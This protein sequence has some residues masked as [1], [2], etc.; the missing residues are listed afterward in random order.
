MASEA[1]SG[2][3]PPSHPIWQSERRSASESKNSMPS[4]VRSMTM[5]DLE[6]EGEL[7]LAPGWALFVGRPGD[8]APHAHQALQLC[9]SS[10]NPLFIGSGP[11][12][13]TTG[14]C[15]AIAANTLH[16]ITGGDDGSAF[17]YLDPRTQLGRIVARALGANPGATREPA[18][19]WQNRNS[20]GDRSEG[21]TAQSAGRVRDRI[22]EIWATKAANDESATDERVEATVGRIRSLIRAGVSDARL[23]VR[24]L[25]GTVGLSESRLAALFR[26]GTGVPIRPFVLWT[27]LQLAVETAGRGASL[28]QAAHAA[29]FA[30][31]AHLARTFR[32]M[33]GTT[34]S[35]S[36]RRLRIILLES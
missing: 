28:T 20:Y 30:D 32:R 5:S 10:R 27:R 21:M 11:L 36:V 2:V 6:W 12:A 19:D 3:R 31:S 15:V 22:A 16:S 14:T 25:A 13:G 35:G 18:S 29:G 23:T 8:N 33:F 1:E 17:L 4:L 26:K 34:L 24:D 9:V 7:A